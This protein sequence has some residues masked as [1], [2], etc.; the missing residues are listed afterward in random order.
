[1]K[2]CCAQYEGARWNENGGCNE[3]D[4]EYQRGGG[5]WR[6]EIFDLR[7]IGKRSNIEA[8]IHELK[9]DEEG[10]HDRK[11]SFGKILRGGEN[12]PA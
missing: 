3:Y 11:G 9:E 1:M 12:P 8:Q 2:E 5:Q 4:A 10:L 7:E 6:K